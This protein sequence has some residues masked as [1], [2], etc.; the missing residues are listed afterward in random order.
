MPDEEKNYL[1][2]LL[3]LWRAKEGSP[4][5][6]RASL[7]QP[8][9]RERRGFANLAELFAFLQAQTDPPPKGKEEGMA[10]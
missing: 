4:P 1:S 2:Y 3:R 10:E 7:E 9:T 6:W 8:D 5:A